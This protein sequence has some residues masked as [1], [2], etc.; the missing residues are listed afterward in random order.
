MVRNSYPLSLQYIAVNTFI[1]FIYHESELP[2]VHIYIDRCI[3]Y[4]AQMGPRLDIPF[5]QGYVRE[6]VLLLIFVL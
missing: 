2:L 3:L 4:F 5:H 1:H 6:E